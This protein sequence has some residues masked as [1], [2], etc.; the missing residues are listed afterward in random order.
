MK[1]VKKE[2]YDAVQWNSTYDALKQMLDTFPG[3]VA[4]VNYENEQL[5][6]A[7][8]VDSGYFIEVEHLGWVVD[9]DDS[10]VVYDKDA[11]EDVFDGV[12]EDPTSY[13]W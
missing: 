6:L 3:L 5:E 9:E 13:S 8:R 4:K 10:Y 7:I 1:V 11:F 12:P 2:R